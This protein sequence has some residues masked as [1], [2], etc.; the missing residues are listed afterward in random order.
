M[1]IRD[2]R[3]AAVQALASNYKDDAA[4]L[5]ILKQRATADDDSLCDVQQSKL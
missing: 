3:R 4:T 1:I 5:A 2:V